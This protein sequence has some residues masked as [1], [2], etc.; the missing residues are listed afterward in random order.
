MRLGENSMNNNMRDIKKDLIITWNALKESTRGNGIYTNML[1]EGKCFQ[2]C[3]AVEIPTKERFVTI[4]F[5]SLF[6]TKEKQLPIG[7][8]FE[9]KK[10]AFSDDDL[11][12]WLKIGFGQDPENYYSLSL[13]EYI[14]LVLSNEL[15]EKNS[16]KAFTTV[17]DGVK[18]WQTY[19][20]RIKR[21]RLSEEDELGLFGELCF[22]EVLLDNGIEKAIEFWK[23]PE[24]KAKDYALPHCCV[25]IKTSIG[26]ASEFKVHISSLEQLDDSDCERLFLVCIRTIVSQNGKTLPT[27]IDVIRSKLANNQQVLNDFEMKL[28]KSGYSDS[29]ESLYLKGFECNE[30]LV[31]PVDNNFP[32]LT[33]KRIPSSIISAEYVL[34]LSESFPQIINIEDLIENHCKEDLK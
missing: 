29:Q 19:M 34:R 30:M 24:K 6:I 5:K 18:D 32:C 25:E 26:S 14:Y 4:G 23:G 22:L 21:G 20:Q 17:I 7:D 33:S 28:L 13:I 9:F 10:I 3:A 31:Y 16:S 27:K 8:G 1:L 12:G 15:N 2:L 11:Y